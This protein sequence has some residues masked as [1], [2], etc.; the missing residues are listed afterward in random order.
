[1]SGVNSVNIGNQVMTG[2]LNQVADR[3]SQISQQIN[4]T[5][6]N[7]QVALIRLQNEIA[8]YT[9]SISLFSNLLKNLA[10]TDKEV[11]RNS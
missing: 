9:S 7:D 3:S 6:G 4:E 2:G 5:D 8:K 1:M 11:I 10:D